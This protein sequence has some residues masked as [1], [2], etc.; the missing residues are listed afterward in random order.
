MKKTVYL[1]IVSLLL[2][3]VVLCSLTSCISYWSEQFS[4]KM[5][6]FVEVEGGY[7]VR[8]TPLIFGILVTEMNIEER[9]LEIPSEYNGKPVVAI[10]DEGF[11]KCLYAY[12][13][14]IPDTVKVIGDRA[15]QD[16]MLLTKCD[17]PNS[18]TVIGDAAFKGCTCF[19]NVIIPESITT[20]GEEAFFGT[21][22]FMDED[23]ATKIL[24]YLM[25]ITPFIRT[26]TYSVRIP[27]S[28]TSIGAGAFG[29][30]TAVNKFEVDENNTA[31]KAENGV[32]YSQD[33]KILVQYPVAATDTSFTVPD[34][35]E[36]IEKYAFA[37]A[38]NLKGIII[39]TDSNLIRVGDFAFVS[40]ESI[41]SIYFPK[42]VKS[43]GEGAISYCHE[44][45]ECT[46]K[47]SDVVL[48]AK[49]WEQC[50]FLDEMYY[51]GT[52]EQ[53]T[54]YLDAQDFDHSRLYI[55]NIHCSDGTIYLDSDGTYDVIMIPTLPNYP[56]E[57]N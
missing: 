53:M 39:S 40:C 4:D 6:E 36:N 28:V 29:D 12:E 26:E 54:K 37:E 41:R 8:G 17:I 46:F 55:L 1:K 19:S 43:I 24:G 14:I 51:A 15:F 32:L 16:C 35:V 30:T 34:G 22:Q 47:S 23:T 44:L 18:V 20:I 48:G 21:M 11:Y 27:A 7:E 50:T 9:V 49:L 3:A 45:R 57:S 33:G 38:N 10:A 56:Y 2:I 5:F 31:Y 13:I 52:V 25:D 42:S